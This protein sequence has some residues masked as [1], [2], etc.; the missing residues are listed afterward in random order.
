MTKV[1]IYCAHSGPLEE[2]LVHVH[3]YDNVPLEWITAHA[4]AGSLEPVWSSC[5]HV[6]VLMDLAA[7]TVDHR[8][9][10]RA[11][12]ACARTV[13][14]HLPPE[15]QQQARAALE[16]A[17]RWSRGDADLDEL[18]AAAEATDHVYASN[19]DPVVPRVSSAACAVHAAVATA[20]T[21]AGYETPWYDSRQVEEA[22]SHAASFAAA[23]IQSAD[24]DANRE[25]SEPQDAALCPSLAAIVRAQLTCP[26]LDQVRNGLEEMLKRNAAEDG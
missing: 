23:A 10:V 8:T 4:P 13:V 19:A 26:T 24:P 5:D 7:L 1:G 18:A 15:R 20:A 11:A 2:L 22:A 16:V 9:L 3:C 17:E 14:V 12:C 21:A 25:D 6:R